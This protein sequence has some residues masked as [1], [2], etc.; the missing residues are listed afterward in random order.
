MSF[1]TRMRKGYNMSMTRK[2]S[3]GVPDWGSPSTETLI[4]LTSGYAAGISKTFTQ[5]GFLRVTYGGHITLNSSSTD[6]TILYING[7]D[8]V[9][10]GVSSTT[11]VESTAM[12]PVSKGDKFTWTGAYVE[13]GGFI[14]VEF[15]PCKK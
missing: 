6:A 9:L 11:E 3:G 14:I 12:Y 10:T 15:I 5:D 4:N 13:N 8:M 2:R 1:N 7:A